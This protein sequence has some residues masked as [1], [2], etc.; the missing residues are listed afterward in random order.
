MGAVVFSSSRSDLTSM[1][2][3]RRDQIN[4]VPVLLFRAI[5]STPGEVIPSKNDRCPRPES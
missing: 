5:P 4:L 2:E 3:V 1:S